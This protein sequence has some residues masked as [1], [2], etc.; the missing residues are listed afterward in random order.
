MDAAADG[1]REE[2]VVAFPPD[3]R[4][5]AVGVV[6][7]KSRATELKELQQEKRVRLWRV[8]GTLSDHVPLAGSV[9]EVLLERTHHKLFLNED[10]LRIYLHHGGRNA[11]YYEFVSSDADGQVQ[12]IEVEV[13]TDLPS[14]AFLFA[15]QPLNQ[16]LDA[17]ARIEPRMPLLF[18]RLEL[19]SP[20]RGD[21][22]CYELLLPF[23]NGARMGP[24]GG[25]QQ[26]PQFAPYDAIFREALTT[27][28]PFYRLLCAYRA[29]DGVAWIRRWV[30][31]T[32][33]RFNVVARMPGD[34]V[35]DVGSLVRM[36]FSNEFCTG[37]R[38]ANDLFGRLRDL[39]DGIAHFLAGDRQAEGHT[40]IASGEQWVN[41]SLG[42]AI[43]L[44]YAGQAI[45]DL[46]NFCNA[47]LGNHLLRGSILPL[48]ERRHDFVVRAPRERG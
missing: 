21:T 8:R 23:V 4:P 44:G 48:P 32:C 37:I 18:S 2:F 40:Y 47:H 30:R 34:P 43:L 1:P 10:P 39:R 15:R 19:I 41:Y 24:L 42:G 7:L 28:S 29:Y 31:E 26:W 6:L 36:G 33:D 22:L 45:D 25:F 17:I 35:V 14:S 3:P 9:E 46:R 38:T 16:M 5:G 12:Y 13:E 11:I 27:S 20:T